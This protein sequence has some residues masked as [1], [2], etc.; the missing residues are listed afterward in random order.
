MKIYLNRKHKTIKMSPV[1]AE[2]DLNEPIV[3]STYFERYIASGGKKCKAKHKVGDS[4]C[5]WKKRGNFHRGYNEDFSRE[6]FIMTKVLK[7]IACTK[8]QTKRLF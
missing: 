8:I 4:V 7:K 5:I 1:D 2:K 3:R 6:H